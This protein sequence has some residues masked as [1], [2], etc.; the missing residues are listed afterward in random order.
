[1]FLK[2]KP[3]YPIGKRNEM[4][5]FAA[6]ST[7]LNDIKDTSVYITASSFYQLWVNGK[8]VS[9]GPARTAKGYSRVDVISIE[10]YAVDG[11]NKIVVLVSGYVCRSLSTVKQSSYLQAEIRKN[12]TVLRATGYDFE[13]YL[14]VQKV[15]KVRRYSMQRQ[16]SEVWNF[17]NGCNYCLPEYKADIEVLTEPLIALDRRA[18]YPYYEDIML[19][20]VESKGKL[21]FDESL[22]YRSEPYSYKYTDSKEAFDES[23]II[24]HPFEWVQRHDQIITSSNCSF[25]VEIGENE[26][27]FLDFSKIETGF[28]K[29][30]AYVEDDADII[31]GMSE[32]VSG[33]K[34]QFN[35]TNINMYAAVEVLAKKGEKLDFISFEPYVGRFFIVAVKKGKINF[36]NFGIK[37]FMHNPN[38]VLVKAPEDEQLKSIFNG[39]VRTFN[40]NAVDI[41]MDC[42]SRERA[43]WLCDSYFTGKVEYVLYGTTQIEDAFL[44]N[45]RL[46]KNDGTYPQGVIPMCYPSDPHANAEFRPQYI[47]QWTMW[48]I[49][50]VEDYINNRN[51]KNDAHLFKESIFGLLDFYNRYE[52]SDGLLE[53]LPSWNFVEWSKANS[54]TKNV[55]YPTN[56]LYAQVLECVYKLF[57]DKKYFEKAENIRK[58]VIEKSF[59]GDRFY[60]H[61]LRNENGELVLQKDCSE[62]A[63]YYAVLFGGFDINDKKF[64]KLKSHIQNDYAEGS[65]T[66]PS[67]MEPINAFIGVYLRLEALL[68]IEEYSLVIQD[69]R[70]F[71]GEME[72][73][74]GTLW[75]CRQHHGSRDHGFASYALVAMLKALNGLKNN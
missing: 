12:G 24:Y 25:P 40:H 71:F 68:K 3:I 63:Q 9:F 58:K 43:G 21:V 18:A 49:L 62:I 26:Y 16:F 2:A 48:Y 39:A 73:E 32:D 17:E 6:F 34:F 41:Y 4:N 27:A 65:K 46:Y 45:Y 22:S 31:I 64:L 69:I 10:D 42:P 11:E 23:E 1:M 8:F 28:I 14:P 20:G 66:F 60:D 57:G 74:T 51:H 75:E 36:E 38:G 67:D 5:T 50:E 72:K 33:G 70:S 15:Q 61:S 44:E 47:P 35:Y 19:N 55:N 56:F 52:N 7:T 54:W 59:D 37:T 29:L 53:D 30:Q 13:A